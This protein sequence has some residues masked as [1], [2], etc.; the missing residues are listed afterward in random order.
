MGRKPADRAGRNVTIAEVARL[1]G[2]SSAVVSYVL[3][4][5]PRPVAPATAVRVREAITLLGYRP[6][7]SARALRSGT[8][9]VLGLVLPGTGNPFFGEF[10]DVIYQ[11][12]AQASLALLTANSAGSAATERRLIDDLVGRSVD[13]ILV[14]TSMTTAD[15]PSLRDPGLPLLL[16]NCPFP[17]PGYRAIGPASADGSRRLVNHLLTVHHHQQVAL[18]AGATTTA[19]PEER[20]AGWR[21]AHLAAGLAEGE[22][23]RAPF[24]IDGGYQAARQLLTRPSRPTAIFVSSDLQ[25]FG[26][27]HA[28]HELGLRIPHD[29]A[30]VSFDGAQESAHTWPPLTLVRQ[31][32]E[33][34]ANA[35]IADV[36][37]AGPPTHTLFDM[38]LIIRQ[39]CGCNSGDSAGG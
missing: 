32:L 7:S 34:M 21:A 12:A 24:T 29:I 23:L 3:N 2:V 4:D 31:P 6:N 14:V 25:A 27:L 20:E 28:I 38:E 15:I 9:G 37:Q 39:S 16:V 36:L 10:N 17:V 8:T 1:A 30:I 5:G 26:S 19:E 11:A 18:I 22:V 13:G 33:A 35:A